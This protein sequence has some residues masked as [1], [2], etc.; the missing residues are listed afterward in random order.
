MATK[1]FR[2]DD[3]IA[4]KVKKVIGNRS[5]SD[6]FREAVM[7]KLDREGDYLELL[8]SKKERIEIELGKIE[9]LI[10]EEE[11]RRYGNNGKRPVKVSNPVIKRTSLDN[12]ANWNKNKNKIPSLIKIKTVDGLLADVKYLS[13]VADSFNV[14]Y[15]FLRQKITE[16]YGKTVM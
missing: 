6:F 8:Y 16:E 3:D 5:E 10:N 2:I 7:E 12:E 4:E 9:V 14:D 15:K 13:T 1:N 11:S